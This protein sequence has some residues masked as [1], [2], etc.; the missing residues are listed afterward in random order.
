MKKGRDQMNYNR[1]RATDQYSWAADEGLEAELDHR[2]EVLSWER[3]DRDLES[4]LSAAVDAEAQIRKKKTPNSPFILLERTL[5][6]Q[7]TDARARVVAS[8]DDLGTG[9]EG[10]VI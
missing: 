6:S 8:M 3:R 4:K 7:M 10:I 1:R 9:V 5:D 2:R